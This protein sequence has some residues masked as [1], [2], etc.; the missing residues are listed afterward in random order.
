MFELWPHWYTHPVRANSSTSNLIDSIRPDLKPETLKSVEQK[1]TTILQSGGLQAPRKCKAKQRV[2][3]IV[4]FTYHRD[5]LP[6]FLK[7]MHTFLIK[8]PIEYQIFIVKQ[9]PGQQFNR[10]ALF[11]AGYVEAMKMEAWDCFI[12]HDINLIPT[13]D[14]NFYTCAKQNPRHMSVAIDKSF[15]R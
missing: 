11:N 3:I 12:F 10:G 8:Q 5:E 7:N 4:P 9:I 1:F 2:A 6:I 14:N 13:N 15:Y